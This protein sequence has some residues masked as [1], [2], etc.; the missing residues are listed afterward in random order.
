MR[1]LA[2]SAGALVVAASFSSCSSVGKGSTA[3]EVNGHRLSTDELATLS[4]DSSD[5]KVIRDTLSTWI[6]V[7]AVTNDPSGLT[8]ADE[9]A[10]RKQTA[11]ADLLER[12]GDSGRA[13][14]ELG[15]DGSPFLCLRAIPLDAAVTG[16][17]VLQE[18][19]AGTTFTDAAG[20]YSVDETLASSG[21]LVKSE[22]GFE[23]IASSE[24]NP[25]LIAALGESDAVV[26]KPV[27]MQ[28][29]EQE[30]VVLLRPY[31]E[32]TLS[33]AERLQLSANDLGG[34]LDERYD[35]AEISVSSRLGQWDATQGRVVA[36][37]TVI[38]VAPATTLPAPTG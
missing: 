13:I 12:F 4:N 37:G 9:L 30:V 19:A 24:F 18:L 28:L 29:G 15:I 17:S 7:V 2:L 31:D 14:Y 10:A 1:R 11:L 32:L 22:K 8:S 3:A 16:A 20:A 26:G 38:G 25:A 6:E 5:V 33:N 35:A 36:T 21:G 34:A 23:C 27:A